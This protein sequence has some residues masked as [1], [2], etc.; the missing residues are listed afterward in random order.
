[1]LSSDQSK[2]AHVLS[3][4][5]AV[6]F[7][8]KW[9]ISM[10]Q[11]ESM[12]HND[13]LL[14]AKS[15]EKV[16]LKS[17]FQVIE[18]KVDCY[19]RVELHQ[20][21]PTFANMD[22]SCKIKDEKCKHNLEELAGEYRMNNWPLAGSSGAEIGLSTVDT[23][24]SAAI[25]LAFDLSFGVDAWAG[26]EL[27]AAGAVFFR[28]SVT[29]NFEKSAES[30]DVAKYGVA[31]G[32]AI[33]SSCTMK[34]LIHPWLPWLLPKITNLIN[35]QLSSFGRQRLDIFSASQEWAVRDAYLQLPSKGLWCLSAWALCQFWIHKYPILLNHK[36][37]RGW[38]CP[39]SPTFAPLN[40]FL[41]KAC[42]TRS[43]QPPHC[44]LEFLCYLWFFSTEIGL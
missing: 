39:S 20:I 4:I 31:P 36:F 44:L 14:T 26:L 29:A 12:T 19:L 22:K 9:E 34:K 27:I 42:N 8:P 18:R 40:E 10:K 41:A 23:T 21:M 32:I 38:V 1:M 25:G 16:T 37:V 30:P 33:S 13:E 6:A 7:W 5:L 17:K 43:M 35:Q 15:S 3:L 28:L 11:T 24:G 2:S